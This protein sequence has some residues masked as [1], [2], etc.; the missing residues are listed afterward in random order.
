[1]LVIICMEQAWR[2]CYMSPVQLHQK[3]KHHTHA[4]VEIE[5]EK[6][7]TVGNKWRREEEEGEKI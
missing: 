5:Y 7:K 3:Q 2:I 4:V 1:M 6:F